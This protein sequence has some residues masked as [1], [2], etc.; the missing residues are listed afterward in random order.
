MN[1]LQEKLEKTSNDTFL[2][3]KAWKCWEVPQGITFGN[4]EENEY[5]KHYVRN[6]YLIPDDF[7]IKSAREF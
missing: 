4:K 2:Y 5:L 6:L 7:D 3:L 1:E